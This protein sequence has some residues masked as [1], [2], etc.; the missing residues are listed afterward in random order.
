M[1]RISSDPLVG[2]LPEDLAIDENAVSDALIEKYSP[3][4]K[5]A[6]EFIRA[7]LTR[8]LVEY[9][10]NALRASRY[11]KGSTV[12]QAVKEVFDKIPDI[13]RHLRIEYLDE[14]IVVSL[15]H[16]L[17]LYY[18]ILDKG[19]SFIKPLNLTTRALKILTENA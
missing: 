7:E 10:A 4:M 18:N 16:D 8:A 3:L 2:I 1:I 14:S 13:V 11:R 9:R 17:D 5:E 15:P 12:A 6:L 19:N